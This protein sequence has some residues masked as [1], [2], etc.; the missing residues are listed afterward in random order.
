MILSKQIYIII[1]Q[2]L[3]TGDI[4][5]LF[6]L[7]M[8]SCLMHA[9]MTIKDNVIPECLYRESIFWNHQSFTSPSLKF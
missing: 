5:F 3:K 4:F 9:G 6:L 7:V 1:M 8:D 2:H